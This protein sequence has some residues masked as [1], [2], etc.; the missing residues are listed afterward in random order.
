MRASA[1][2]HSAC[3]QAPNWRA[4]LSPRPTLHLTLRLTLRR[5]QDAMRKIRAVGNWRLQHRRESDAWRRR[6]SLAL[7]MTPLELE[8]T[9]T[10]AKSPRGS[11]AKG[12]PAAR[13]SS[14]GGGGGCS[15]V[16]G[17]GA[18]RFGGA[19]PRAKIAAAVGAA[20]TASGAAVSQEVQTASQR[21]SE[22]FE[23]AN[24]RGL[25]GYVP[26]GRR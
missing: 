25:W 2:E 23:K 10:P 16:R 19:S 13:T 9:G 12:S 24:S 1:C 17:G 3:A 6:R 15:P 4:R 21:F 20:S 26:P 14:S 5:F 8:Y 11:P 18:A 22:A 7:A